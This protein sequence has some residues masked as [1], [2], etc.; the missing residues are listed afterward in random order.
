MRFILSLQA[1]F[2]VVIYATWGPSPLRF[3]P[4]PSFWHFAT[5]S[6][7]GMMTYSYHSFVY[8]IAVAPPGTHACTLDIE[9]FHRTCPVA[10]DHKPWLVVQ[11][12]PGD[13]F[14]DHCHPFGAACASS[15]AGMIANAAV[16][17]W[18]A[19]GI[20][21][22]LKYEDDLN[23]FRYPLTGGPFRDGA[24]SYA[25]DR[26][27]ALRRIQSLGVPWHPEKGTLH[28]SSTFTFIG[29]LWDIDQHRVSL[30][31]NKQLK[32]LR[33]VDDFVN[34][35]ER[36]Q[37]QL[38]DV[39]RIHGSLCYI[40]FIYV[41]GR[42]RLPSLS[43]FAASFHGNT[44]ISRFPPRSMISDLKWWSQYLKNIS[45]FRQLT[46]R[47][48]SLDLGIFADASTS[49]GIGIIFGGEWMAWQLS[50]SWK[51]P[52][53]DICWLE[54]LAIEFIAHILEVKD[55]RD[56]SVIIH[57][58][59]QGTIGSMHK[60]RSP[61]IYIN[62]SICRI[63]AILIPRF[64]TPI[65]IYVSTKDN[66]ADP[67][68]RGESDPLRLRLVKPFKLPDELHGNFLHAC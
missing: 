31:E 43:N 14:I 55:F 42:S 18:M 29:M 2:L 23:I 33:R 16:D 13:F 4:H 39:E 27:E 64:I 44:F 26:E 12:Q 20:K 61:N 5:L 57:S 52:G 9:K 17:I 51:I 41:E 35:F 46:P 40:S 62:E 15:N 60:G 53:R 63:Y 24:F 66:P 34:A 67:L 38:R 7:L 36:R 32:F 30:P 45:F 59:N 58:D 49:W 11:G 1:F 68:S 10:P 21:P 56:C 6:H 50:P 37:C 19:E 3:L 48:P 28:F 65:L 47:G 8:Q 54:T 22:I 25:Y